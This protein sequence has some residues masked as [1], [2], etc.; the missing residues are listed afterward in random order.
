MYNYYTDLKIKKKQLEEQKEEER[1]KRRKKLHDKKMKEYTRNYENRI[2]NFIYNMAEKPIHLRENPKPFSTTREEFLTEES[3][4]ILFHKGFIFNLYQTDK[5]RVNAY[6][7]EREKYEEYMNSLVNHPHP[8][9]KR[10]NIPQTNNIDYTQSFS[11][12]KININANN[13]INYNDNN[14]TN[15]NDNFNS[16][17]KITQP[18]MRFKPRSDLERIYNVLQENQP[19]NL[20]TLGYRSKKVIEK[21]L[22]KMGFKAKIEEQGKSPEDIIEDNKFKSIEELINENRKDIIDKEKKKN[23]KKKFD[24]ISKVK[25]KRVDNSNA[26]ALYPDLYNKTYFNAVENYSLFKNSCFLPKKFNNTIIPNKIN[27]FNRTSQ[28]VHHKKMPKIIDDKN[29]RRKKTENDIFSDENSY[30]NYSKINAS[31]PGDLV[32]FLNN[33][34]N[35]TIKEE[36][37]IKSLDNV[38]LFTQGLRENRHKLTKKEKINFDIIKSMAFEKKKKRNYM[39]LQF[40]SKTEVPKLNVNENLNN[41][42]DEDDN[43]DN[44][45]ME[46]YTMKKTEE[47]IK[48]DGIEYSKNDLENLSKA[49]MN[50]CKYTRKKYRSSDS[51]FSKPGKGKLM[52]TGGLTIEEFEKKYHIYG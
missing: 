13:N 46:D 6:Q 35:P 44:D 16:F 21:Q 12:D 4:K 38:D 1:K 17:L 26:K 24:V 23:E 36:N 34:R 29:L 5:E 2:K 31:S 43:D 49:I 27:Q 7:N 45:G 39:S 30:N 40:E 42:I 32:N 9:P 15:E 18:Q 8:L 28:N 20:G 48:I 37:L 22:H 52:F 10:N 47:K 3:D 33:C 50:K 25:K 41:I 51:E 14:N 19:N 11:Q